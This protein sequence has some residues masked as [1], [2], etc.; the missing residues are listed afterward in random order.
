MTKKYSKPILLLS[1]CWL[2]IGSWVL[3]LALILVFLYGFF[4]KAI[5]E[6]FL[7]L[8]GGFAVIVVLSVFATLVHK[9]SHCGRRFL[10]EFPGKKH[11]LARKRMALDHWASTVLDIVSEGRFVCMYCGEEYR[12]RE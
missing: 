5:L 9:C 6:V 12:T 1:T 3:L 2:L 4:D 10:L 7:A 8:F 11:P